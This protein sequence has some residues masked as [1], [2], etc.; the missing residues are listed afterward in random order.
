VR[1]LA[2]SLFKAGRERA[3]AALLFDILAKTIKGF[4][5]L[6]R[7]FFWQAKLV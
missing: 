5:S 2:A 6:S 7:R 3:N 4:S 1:F